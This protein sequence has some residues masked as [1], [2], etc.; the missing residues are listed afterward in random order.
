MQPVQAGLANGLEIIEGFLHHGLGPRIGGD[1]HD[2]GKGVAQIPSTS[3]SWSVFM[4]RLL[5][6]CRNTVL[7]PDNSQW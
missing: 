1:P 7:P 5:A 3:T 6:S 4:I 2:G